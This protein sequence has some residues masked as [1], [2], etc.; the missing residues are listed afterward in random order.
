M[1]RHR[2]NHEDGPPAVVVRIPRA[3]RAAGCRAR[4]A[5]HVGPLLGHTRGFKPINPDKTIT[6]F[7][8]T[9]VVLAFRATRGFSWEK[10]PATAFASIQGS[11]RL[12][13]KTSVQARSFHSKR[14]RGRGV[15][16]RAHHGEC[17]AQHPHTSFLI[18]KNNLPQ[19]ETVMEKT[20]T[21]I[22]EVCCLAVCTPDSNSQ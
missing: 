21:E 3:R 15:C 13:G 14:R 4:R 20:A 5:A 19:M 12:C 8:R 6:P 22:H 17:T 16:D 9:A 11:G 1:N 2:H 18:D 10:A 7:I